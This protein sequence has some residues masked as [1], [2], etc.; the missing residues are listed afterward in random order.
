MDGI[1]TRLSLREIEILVDS[2]ESKSLRSPFTEVGFKQVFGNNTGPEVF[3][4]LQHLSSQ[5]FTDDQ[6]LISLNI[7]KSDREKRGK[8]ISDA[9][10][11]VWT[12]PEAP[13]IINRD[14]KVVVQELFS[15]AKESVLVA[16]FA[17]Y[18]GRD[19]FKAL[20]TQMDSNPNLKVSMYL[21][22]QRRHMDTTASEYLLQDFSDK[23]KK[24]D[25]PGKR[26]PEVF[27]DPRSL[28]VNTDKKAALHAKCIV[29]DRKISFVSSANFTEA[30]QERNIEAGVLV[31][32]IEFSE[33]LQ[34]H[35]ETLVHTAYLKPIPKIMESK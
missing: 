31:D 9:V 6:I 4:A 2:L 29:V 27:Y 16:G 10:S 5:T 30:A 13:G 32:S 1:L 33:Q 22:V 25:W 12:G 11:L 26:L 19:V 20:A 14:T 28:S 3:R 17:V 21:N 15:K 34:S 35:F 23:F 24:K 18:Q 8:S 7:L